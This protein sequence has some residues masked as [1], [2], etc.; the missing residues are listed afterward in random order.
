MSTSSFQNVRA[1]LAA[2]IVARLTTDAVTGVTVFEYRPMGDIATRED[3]VW[4]DRVR[5][6]Q[7]PL[8]MGGP[9]RLVDETVTLDLSVRAPRVG[10]D[11]DDMKL[12]EQRAELIWASIE[13]ALRNSSSV[14]S[15]VMFA[16]IEAF[17]SIP[18]Y[19][20]LGAIGTIEATVT[21]VANL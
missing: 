3:M 16:D 4:I 12:A 8:S 18:D 5:I 9:S 7:E 19:D 10:A 15:T 13:T 21:A 17:E 1:A 6:D 11:Q 2:L 20:E 14:S